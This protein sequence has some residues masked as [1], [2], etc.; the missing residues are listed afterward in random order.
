VR[1]LL[2]VWLLVCALPAQALAAAMMLHCHV[3]GPQR[4]ALAGHAAGPGTLASADHAAHGAHAGH[5]GHA[6][7]GPQAGS[8]AHDPSHAD[9]AAAGVCSACAACCLGA[10]PVPHPSARPASQVGQCVPTAP[11]ACLRSAVVDLPD[12]PPRPTLA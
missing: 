6:D 10:A 3:G 7:P 8:S 11:V 12:R 1:R 2:L 4:H 5:A 9:H